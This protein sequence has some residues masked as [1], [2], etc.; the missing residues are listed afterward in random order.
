MVVLVVA[1]DKRSLRRPKQTVHPPRRRRT[2]EAKVNQNP[3]AVSVFAPISRPFIACL[4]SANRAMSMANAISVINAARKAT[5][6]ATSVIVMCVENDRRNAINVT[7]VATENKNNKVSLR[8]GYRSSSMS[9][10]YRQG[11]R[12]VHAS[13]KV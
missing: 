7:A 5:N 1:L 2:S 10:A 13:M 9:L 11:E 4:T 3:G 12:P 8:C 6:D